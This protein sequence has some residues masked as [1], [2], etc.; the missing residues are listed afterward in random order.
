[1]FYGRAAGGACAKTNWSSPP[2][3]Y[4]MRR[5]AAKSLAILC[6]GCLLVVAT[7][8]NCGEYLLLHYLCCPDCDAA[9][10]AALEAAN[11]SNEQPPST[12]TTEEEESQDESIAVEGT[13]PHHTPGQTLPPPSTCSRGDLNGDGNVDGLDIQILVNCLLAQ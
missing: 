5:H 3:G 9:K 1:M 10:L 13:L 11:S 7:N 2:G 4:D 8:A 12:A 6:L